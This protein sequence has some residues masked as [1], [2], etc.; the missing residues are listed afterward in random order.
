MT[1]IEADIMHENGSFWVGRDTVTSDETGGQVNAYVVYRPRGTVSESAAAFP[2]TD[3]GLSLA[4]AYCDY[5]AKSANEK[6]VT[7]PATAPKGSLD[8]TD[9]H[10]LRE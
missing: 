1:M 3:D 8:A 5:M 9:H 7:G 10:S 6:A 2:R 4:I